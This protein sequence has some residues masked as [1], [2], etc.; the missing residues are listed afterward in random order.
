MP[1][2]PSSSPLSAL[3]AINKPT[4]VTSMS[5]LNNLQPLLQS[6]TLFAKQQQPRHPNDKSR[7]RK[8]KQERIKIGQGGTLDPLADGVLVV[9]VNNAT[10]Q[11]AS[12]LDCTKEYRAIGLLG[13]STDSYDSE[14]KVVKRAG[15][16][17]ITK[18]SIEEALAQFRGEIDQVPPV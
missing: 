17:G 12:F 5:L 2:V 10:K 7:R 13:A 8:S 9:G 4:G 1:K 3:F 11:L 18:Q 15:F 14:G 16:E 6:S